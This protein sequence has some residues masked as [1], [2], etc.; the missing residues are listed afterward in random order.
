MLWIGYVM[1]IIEF[2]R[3]IGKN[4]LDRDENKTGLDDLVGKVIVSLTDIIE[5]IFIYWQGEE[6]VN[7]LYHSAEKLLE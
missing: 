5:A 4:F 2:A 1:M 3:E 6:T 7:K